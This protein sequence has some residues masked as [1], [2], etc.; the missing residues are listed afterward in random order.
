MTVEKNSV[1]LMWFNKYSGTIIK[2]P[3]VEIVIDPVDISP[4]GIEVLNPHIIVI[5]HEHY[6]HFDKKIVMQLQK[7][8][9]VIIGPSHVIRE[10]KGSISDEFLKEI[11]AGEETE[12]NR[13]KIIAQKADHP[14]P[15]PLTFVFITE[16]GIT[17]Y[18]AIDSR[19]FD[20]MKS[21]GEKYKPDIAIVP[22]GI[23]PG[24]SPEEGARAI[25]LLNPKVAIPHHATKGF[26]K[27]ME[28]TKKLVPH[29][30]IK[31]LETGEIFTYKRE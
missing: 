26:E 9:A 11:H 3:N 13:F 6:D 20:D 2:S 14:S 23:A 25:S 21:I 31:L 10:L 27:F 28:I 1:A 29:V 7:D 8:K 16:D 24:T 4:K 30:S 12:I 5:S 22:I 17:I 18:H 19:T 15:E